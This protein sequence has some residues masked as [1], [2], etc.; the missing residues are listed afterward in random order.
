MFS[1]YILSFSFSGRYNH[2]SKQLISGMWAQKGTT[3]ALLR[4]TEFVET[5]MHSLSL[6][7][8][9]LPVAFWTLTV[10]FFH[11]NNN[12]PFVAVVSVSEFPRVE[13]GGKE[14]H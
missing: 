13:G 12:K 1:Y 6:A 11:L 14:T 7:A 4:W 2:S 3:L 5:Q 9:S 8:L 10:Q